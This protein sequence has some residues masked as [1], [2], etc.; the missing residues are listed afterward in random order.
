MIWSFAGPVIFV[1]LVN[2]A[3]FVEALVIAK[4]SLQKRSEKAKSG[5]N[6]ITLLKGNTDYNDA[7]SVSYQMFLLSVVESSLSMQ[8][9]VCTCAIHCA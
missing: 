1:L 5:S 4:R 2:T 3:M 9:D 7:K 6:T 8:P